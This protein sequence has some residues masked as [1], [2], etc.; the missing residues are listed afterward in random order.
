MTCGRDQLPPHPRPEP[1]RDRVGSRRTARRAS[2]TGARGHH[3]PGESNLSGENVTFR[4][5]NRTH[6]KGKCGVRAPGS[7][8][9]TVHGLVSHLPPLWPPPEQKGRRQI[10]TT[11]PHLRK[12]YQKGVDLVPEGVTTPL[13]GCPTWPSVTEPLRRK[14]GTTPSFTGKKRKDLEGRS[15]LESVGSPRTSTQTR[16]LSDSL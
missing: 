1:R 14:V 8:T 15:R 6:E 10:L 16:A 12:R 4:E 3:A 9:V 13:D 11:P 2:E 5:G 7:E